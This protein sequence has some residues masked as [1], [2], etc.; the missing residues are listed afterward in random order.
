MSAASKLLFGSRTEERFSSSNIKKIGGWAVKA[1]KSTKPK[2][3]LVPTER[4]RLQ[5]AEVLR[6]RQTIAEMHS[7]KPAR[8]DRALLQ[9]RNSVLRGRAFGQRL[10]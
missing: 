10:Q 6:L 5:Y 3:G 7:V 4:I 9:P 1:G 2:T 8:E